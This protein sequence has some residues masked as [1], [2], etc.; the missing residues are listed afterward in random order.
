MRVVPVP[1]N[2]FVMRLRFAIAL[3]SVGAL[4]LDGCG[5]ID[6]LESPGATATQVDR[7]RVAYAHLR[8]QPAGTRANYTSLSAA[9][10]TVVPADRNTLLAAADIAPE[11]Q[12][13]RGSVG[14]TENALLWLLAVPLL[15]EA[16]VGAQITT[17]VLA[18]T[19][20]IAASV[21]LQNSGA[22]DAIREDLTS[23]GTTLG[24]KRA[25]SDLQ[26]ESAQVVGSISTPDAQ[27]TIPAVMT[28]EDFAALADWIRR[29]QRRSLVLDA[30]TLPILLSALNHLPETTQRA[31]FNE[32]AEPPADTI[33]T[34]TPGD[35]SYNHVETLTIMKG[36][37]ILGSGD[38]ENCGGLDQEC[39]NDAAAREKGWV[40]GNNFHLCDPAGFENRGRFSGPGSMLI[41]RA[42]GAPVDYLLQ[43]TL[44]ARGIPVYPV[45]GAA[46]PKGYRLVWD[47]TCTDGGP[48]SPSPA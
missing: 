21:A 34:G 3:V 46:K 20:G 26:D 22:T 4:L 25:V 36:G 7:S 41:K 39:C 14:R 24:L 48:K 9:L 40:E 35:V 6:P 31:L 8:M 47:C 27:V 32:S 19:A 17:F 42:I 28:D 13:D 43:V 45:E 38:P 11:L 1:A 23:L 18:V 16:G 44:K 37:H 29:R 33:L 5:L 2:G 12:S 10:E 30:T 15:A